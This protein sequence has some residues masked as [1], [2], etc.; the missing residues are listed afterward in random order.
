MYLAGLKKKSEPLEKKQLVEIANEIADLLK[1]GDIVTLKGDLGCGK[2]FFCNAL[3]KRLCPSVAQAPSPTFSVMHLYEDGPFPICHFD[4]YKLPSLE[5]FLLRGL[6]E[7][8]SPPYVSLIEWPNKIE[9]ILPNSVWAI[10][11]AHAS[12]T[13]RTIYVKKTPKATV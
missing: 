1:P 5:D 12:K 4:I 11:L 3:I 9:S 13:T 7:F 6:D 10:E 2:T 8:L